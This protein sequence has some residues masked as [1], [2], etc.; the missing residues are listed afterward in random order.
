MQGAQLVGVQPEPRPVREQQH[1]LVAG[2]GGEQVA[3]RHLLATRPDAEAQ[4]EPVAVAVD[5]GLSRPGGIRAV[6]RP[7]VPGGHLHDRAVLDLGVGQV[8]ADEGDVDVV[9]F[10][11]RREDVAGELHGGPAGELGLEDHPEAR[12]AR[13][14]DAQPGRPVE[15]VEAGEQRLLAVG[16]AD[17]GLGGAGVVVLG[18]ARREQ[19][20]VVGDL[21]DGIPERPAEPGE[22]PGLE[23]DRQPEV[24]R[25][26]LG[27]ED[28]AVAGGEGG[29]TAQ[30]GGVCREEALGVRRRN[31][32]PPGLAEQGGDR[33]AER[34]GQRCEH[35][36]VLV[37]GSQPVAGVTDQLRRRGGAGQVHDRGQ[38]DGRVGVPREVERE[39]DGV[40]QPDGPST[41]PGHQGD[42]GVGRVAQQ[43][44]D[45][46]PQS[47]GLD[48]LPGVVP[49]RRAGRLC[50][51][52]GGQ[53]GP[54]P[55]VGAGRGVAPVQVGP[56]DP[57]LDPGARGSPD[58][59]LQA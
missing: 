40:G 3:Q 26:D 15:D 37:P 55:V 2:Q 29:V 1:L 25:A 58:Q 6:F 22:V 19:G 46:R 34:T 14:G 10:L 56:G 17:H 21:A 51:H 59:R 38:G 30:G 16:V 32:Q 8:L 23:G 33:L 52:D 11:Q 45:G 7:E 27:D 5:A 4:A 24:R 57:G 18:I 42:A 9:P 44:P 49:V 54:V 48:P 13:Q 35:H 31:P 20:D 36:P 12:L 43:R 28:A 50:L 53:R 41:T 39:L 47:G